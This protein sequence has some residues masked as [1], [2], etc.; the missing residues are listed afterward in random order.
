MN[1]GRAIVQRVS[2][3]ATAQN[4][5]A[6]GARGRVIDKA[7]RRAA[8]RVLVRIGDRQRTGGRQ[9]S[10]L[11][12]SA[13]GRAYDSRRIIG[14]RNG[15]DD[16]LIVRDGSVGRPDQIGQHQTIAVVQRI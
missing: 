8:T 14:T 10:I 3:G 2:P 9:R 1:R 5:V 15:N 4:K 16:V 6:I 13:G 7:R 12:H 11:R